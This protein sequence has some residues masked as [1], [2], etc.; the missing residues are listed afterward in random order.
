MTIRT[1][2]RRFAAGSMLITILVGLFTLPFSPALGQGA[3]VEI[4]EPR[5]PPG[6]DVFDLN[7]EQTRALS[8]SLNLKVVGHS[9]LKGSHLTRTAKAEGTGAG[10]NGAY[11]HNGIAYLASYSDP[12]TLFGHLIVDVHNPEDMKVLSFVPCEPGARCPYLRVNTKRHILVGG[13]SPGMPNAIDA[14]PIQPP[15]GASNARAGISFIDVSN[16]KSPKPLGFFLTDLGGATHDFAIDD[17]FVYTCASMPESK[18]PGVAHQEVV[19]IDYR[20]PTNPTLAGRL[21]LPGQHVGEEYGARDRLNP[22]GSPQKVWCQQI[23]IHKNRLYVGWR[24]AG[25]VVV[26]VTDPSNPKPVGQ[27]DYVPPFNGGAMGAAHTAAPVIVDPNEHPDLVIL[28]DESFDCPPGIGRIIDVSDLKNPEVEKGIRDANLQVIS[29]Y[30]IPHVSDVFDFDEGKFECPAG[31]QSAHLPWLDHRSP[32]LVYHTWYDQGVRVWD[33]SNPFL[34]REVGYYLPPKYASYGYVDRQ[35][36]EVFQDPDTDLIYV[37]DGN[38]G[39]LTVL[40]WTGPIPEHPPI[41]GAR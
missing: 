6:T 29:S 38:G 26:D 4:D 41:P 11:V 18:K 1:W 21:H 30:R 27:L 2:T 12:P 9:Y 25:L 36:R 35:T 20:D 24:D 5:I 32:S 31:Q 14:N 13:H 3:G 17:N 22:D 16:P 19:I 37:T 8:R 33:I 7:L 34:P 23:T 40:E 15:G 39:G 28:A 10:L